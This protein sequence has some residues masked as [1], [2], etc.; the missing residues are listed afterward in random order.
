MA[1]LG[2]AVVIF[3]SACGGCES[4]RGLL[5]GD[6]EKL[7]WEATLGAR[8][9]LAGRK[10]R[11]WLDCC[12]QAGSGVMFMMAR[13]NWGLLALGWLGSR[14]MPDRSEAFGF[15]NW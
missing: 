14:G 3:G 11:D 7:L 4:E 6:A 1:W 13:Q 12:G 5:K 9:E 10:S 15:W 2:R 8:L